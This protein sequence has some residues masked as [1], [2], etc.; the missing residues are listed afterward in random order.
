MFQFTTTTVINNNVDITSGATKVS[1][2][3]DYFQVLR[4]G[5]F[6]SAKV[7]GA[8]KRPYS[9]GVKE[10]ASIT[11]P[12]GT[13]GDVH[14]LEVVIRLEGSTESD[15]ASPFYYFEKI[16]MVEVLHTGT[17]ATTATALKAQLSK[18]K[19][20]YGHSYFTVGGSGADITLTAKTYYQRFESVKLFKE[21][22]STN[23]MVAPEYSLV[24]TG[25]VTTSGKI[26]FGDYTWMIGNISIPTLDK[27]R[28][29]GTLKDEIP[30][31]DG[32]YSQYT[33]KYAIDKDDDIGIVSGLKSVTEHVFYVESAVTS[34]FETALTT[35][36]I[37]FGLTIAAADESLANSATT[38][39]SATNA[40]GAVTYAVTS[41]TSATVSGN[42][43]TASAATDGDTVIT[44][45]DAVGNTASVTIT[46]A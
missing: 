19:D 13:A 18:F 30:S 10:I 32:N 42:T 39:L 15:Y 3:S 44:G 45:T 31:V 2:A 28:I 25:S 33:L 8:H 41:G 9:A 27:S 22:A 21:Y 34:A 24:A 46:V 36:G 12:A 43:V 35:A 40:V 6:L 4:T 37:G 23:T 11:V 14:R 20:K 26:P 17:A 16:N 1:A 7:V 5:K 29:F 38:T